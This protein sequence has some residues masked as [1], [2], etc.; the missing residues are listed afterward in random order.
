ME[1]FAIGLAIGLTIAIMIKIQAWC[2]NSKLRKENANLKDHLHTQMS[3]N[4]TGYQETCKKL[5]EYKKR[6]QN[7]E[8]TVATLKTKTNKHELETLYTYDR[9]IHM[10]YQKAPGFASAWEAVLDEAKIDME[11]TNRGFKA[12]IKKH[13]SLSRLSKNIV[14]NRTAIA[15]EEKSPPNLI[16]NGQR[17]QN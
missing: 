4:A 12:W 10:M 9:A 15:C 3:I 2:N 13:I 17:N 5:K 6:C 8:I 7:L 1:I 16:T 11:K 14:C